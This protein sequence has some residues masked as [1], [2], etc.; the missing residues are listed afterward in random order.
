M[1]KNL[2]V[3]AKLLAYQF[4]NPEL[5]TQAFTHRSFHNENPS[6]SKGHNE[7]L[8]FLGDAVID[9]IVSEQIFA[10]YPEHEEGE[11]SKIRASLVNEAGLCKVALKLQLGQFMRLGKGEERTMGHEKPRLLSSTFEALVGAIYLDGGYDPAREFILKFLQEEMNQVVDVNTLLGD[12][13]TQLQ[14]HTQKQFKKIPNYQL[15]GELGPDH[16]KTFK[17]KVSLDDQILGEGEGKTKKMAE[18]SAA[19]SAISNLEK[20]GK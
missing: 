5:L 8:E 1:N 9:L 14:E 11:L 2:E 4:K 3:L 20:K 16:D 6:K 13:K 15:V 10:K 19:A 7:R 18:Q 12:Y 17:V